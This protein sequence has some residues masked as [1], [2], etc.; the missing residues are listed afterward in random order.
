MATTL[1]L[2][3]APIS[4]SVASNRD[5]GDA[6]GDPIKTARISLST[7]AALAQPPLSGKAISPSSASA[8]LRLQRVTDTAVRLTVEAL[9]K[10]YN[11]DQEEALNALASNGTIGQIKLVAAPSRRGPKPKDGKSLEELRAECKEARIPFSGS[12]AVLEKRLSAFKSG[13]LAARE[14]TRDELAAQ[15][16]E[17]RLPVSGKRDELVARLAAFERGEIAAKELT[18]A[19]MRAELKRNGWN[20]GGTKTELKE[21]Y[22]RMQNGEESPAA[23]RGPSQKDLQDRCRALGLQTSGNKKVLSER[24]AAAQSAASIS[25]ITT[26]HMTEMMKSP[27]AAPAAGGSITKT[28]FVFNPAIAAAVAATSKPPAD[29]EEEK[30]EKEDNIEEND[31]NDDENDDDD[32]DDEESISVEQIEVNGTAYLLDRSTGVV[33]HAENHTPIGKWNEAS[34]AVELD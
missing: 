25:Q 21:R 24:L 32:D 20:I 4:L 15:C 14:P 26:T 13:T 11:F 19:E 3:T 7:V 27:A 16:A 28:G 34:N 6:G 8:A 2:S 9:S 1:K 10:T 12:R 30:E 31:E 18:S 5:G 17:K 22:Q 23:A 29:G 33:Y